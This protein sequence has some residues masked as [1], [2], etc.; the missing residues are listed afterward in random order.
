MGAVWDIGYLDISL[1]Q[2]LTC[3]YEGYRLRSCHVQCLSSIPPGHKIR[4]AARTCLQ[5]GALGRQY[6]TQAL[7][8]GSL[9]NLEIICSGACAALHWS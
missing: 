7:V 2:S 9:L 8:D 3:E 5:E 6:R 4:A 1:D